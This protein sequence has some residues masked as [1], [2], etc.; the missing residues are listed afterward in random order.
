MTF[1]KREGD[2]TVNFFYNTFFPTRT[3][4]LLLERL[5]PDTDS[6]YLQGFGPKFDISLL[7]NLN[8]VIVGWDCSV[9][10]R[11]NTQNF[12]SFFLI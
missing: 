9:S 2:V 5:L 12:V 11:S 8:T 6:I 4:N 10:P 7:P 3:K 1:K